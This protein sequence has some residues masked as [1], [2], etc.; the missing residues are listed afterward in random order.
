MP[1]KKQSD[2]AA[3]QAW[4]VSE[5]DISKR[6]AC[7][8]ASYTRKILSKLPYVSTK[9]LDSVLS[10][11]WTIQS[12]DMYYVAWGRFVKFMKKEKNYELAKPTKRS[13]TRKSRIKYQIPACVLDSLLSFIKEARIPISMIPAIEWRHFQRVPNAK[14]WEMVDPHNS[15]IYIRVPI[16]PV[17]EIYEWATN[18]QP[19]EYSPLIPIKPQSREAMPVSPL[20]KAIQAHKRSHSRS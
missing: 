8:Y 3:F 4:L 18:G 14:K 6:T 1:K 19:T 5:Y 2:L 17:M 15:S 20:R 10:E 11:A 12:R 13:D 16:G 9:H 7:V